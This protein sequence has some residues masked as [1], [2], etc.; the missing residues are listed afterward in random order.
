MA[1]AIA[2]ALGQGLFVF[3]YFVAVFLHE[4]A[5][6][7]VAR[8]LFYCAQQIKLGIFGATLVGQFDDMPAKDTVKIALAG[9][10]CNVICA[11]C[12]LASWWLYPTL[13]PI[14]HQF[15]VANITMAV[16]NL[17]PLYPLDGG[18]IVFALVAKTCNG[19]I[20]IVV[21]RA[22]TVVSVMLFVLFVVSLFTGDN[23]FSVG[24]F[25]L[26]LATVEVC[27][28][29]YV[30]CAFLRRRLNFGMEK[31]TLVYQQDTPLSAVTKR[32]KGNYLYCLEIVDSQLHVVATLDYQQL[33]DAVV[34]LPP[35]T[36]LC[37]IV[38]CGNES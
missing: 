11:I 22:K 35:T 17:L 6:Y 27:P 2:V 23:L 14:T 31:K 37:Q 30:K 25:A 19:K 13:Y 36:K 20:L 29:G 1:M 33:E 4:L 34:T 32:I 12:C 8:R 24:L 9:P 15:Y 28:T 18:R 7:V 16:T 10:F 5:H 26:C 3:L 21:K 38:S